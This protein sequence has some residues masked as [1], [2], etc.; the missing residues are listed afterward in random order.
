[1]NWD[2]PNRSRAFTLI[3]LLVVIAVIAILAGMLLPVLSRAKEK[4]R[5]AF[6]KSNLKQI[7]LGWT[8]WVHDHEENKLPF[9]IGAVLASPGQYSPYAGTKN[10]PLINNPWLHFSWIS[11]QLGSPKVLLCPS[12]R[13]RRMAYT[14]GQEAQGGFLNAAYK[15]FAISYFLSTDASL[16]VPYEQSQQHILVGDHNLRVDTSSGLPCPVG[17]NNAAGIRL[18][19]PSTSVVGWTN[20][21]HRQIGNIALLDNS[22]HSETRASLRK[23]IAVGDNRLTGNYLHLLMPTAPPP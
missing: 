3:E 1:M 12:D 16:G 11:N 4:G 10:H 23:T 17:L 9:H 6:C 2:R 8:A 15:N 21:V 22:V 7:A 13:R 19:I 18:P 20:G 5:I 14:W